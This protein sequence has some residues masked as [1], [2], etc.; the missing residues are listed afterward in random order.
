MCK[1]FKRVRAAEER[2]RRKELGLC[3]ECPN[4][5]IKGQTRCLDCSKNHSNAQKQQRSRAETRE[6][7][8]QPNPWQT[9]KE[10]GKCI[11][12]SNPTIPGQTRCI[13]CAEQHRI[14]Q[15][16][17][18]TDRRSQ[19]ICRECDQPVGNSTV[20]CQ[21]HLRRRR[22]YKVKSRLARKEAKEKQDAAI[23]KE[24]HKTKSPD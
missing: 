14:Y 10:S 11:H 17:R 7:Q 4:Q 5:A 21:D 15:R 16:K 1:A 23:G 18:D 9:A 19:G 12:C 8:P 20:F 13:T 6:E 2:Q 22:E 24:D 3:R